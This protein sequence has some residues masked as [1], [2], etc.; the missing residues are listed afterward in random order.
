MVLLLKEMV[1]A[2]GEHIVVDYELV[3]E[4]QAQI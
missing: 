1:Q 4:A 2:N 3:A